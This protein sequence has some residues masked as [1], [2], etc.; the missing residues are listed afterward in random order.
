[1]CEVSR[2]VPTG[3]G[4]AG[5]WDWGQLLPPPGCLPAAPMWRWRAFH[6]PGRAHGG[7]STEQ[8]SGCDLQEECSRSSEGGVTP[9]SGG[10]RG[11]LEEASEL[12]LG[13]QVGL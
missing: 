9:P 13:Q 11:F 4:P 7:D 10:S 2:Q 12:K 6:P 8:R 1:M 5:G 3:A